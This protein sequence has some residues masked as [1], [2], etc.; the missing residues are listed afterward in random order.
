MQQLHTCR[1]N[2][3]RAAEEVA[4]YLIEKE[5]DDFEEIHHEVHLEN[6]VLASVLALLQAVESGI[7]PDVN[8]PI[9]Y[10]F[11]EQE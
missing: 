10:V 9:K 4:N 1:K 2:L 8:Y 5:S 6:H 7:I 3:K 11:D